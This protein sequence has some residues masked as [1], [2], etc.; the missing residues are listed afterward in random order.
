MG[1]PRAN[2]AAW[3]ALTGTSS[4]ASRKRG[5]AKGA[6]ADARKTAAPKAVASKSPLSAKAA[7]KL[8]DRPA[9]L[10][11]P[12]DGGADDLKRIAG[13][14]P[15]LESVLNDL[16]IYHFDQIAAWTKKETAWVDTYL[17]FKGRIER[18][19]WIAQ[20]KAFAREAA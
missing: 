13:V 12:K 9:G 15:K 8:G 16:G 10:A 7:P 5:T 6:A 4:A 2:A 14:G 18:D 3:G 1:M 19:G 17:R 20:A 11:A